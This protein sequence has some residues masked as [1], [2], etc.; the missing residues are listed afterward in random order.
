LK[1]N[2][3]FANKAVIAKGAPLRKICTLENVAQ[4][5]MFLCGEQAEFIPEAVLPAGGGRSL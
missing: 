4:S 5:F 2:K 1:P 3:R